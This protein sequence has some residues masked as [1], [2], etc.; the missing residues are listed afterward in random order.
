MFF[1]ELF[2]I[3]PLDI[4]AVLILVLRTCPLKIQ[5]LKFSILCSSNIQVSCFIDMY[6]TRFLFLC[7][8]SA[9]HAK[10]SCS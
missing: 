3:K 1:G 6:H 5:I 4:A 7:K 10:T 9:T 2:S 8:S